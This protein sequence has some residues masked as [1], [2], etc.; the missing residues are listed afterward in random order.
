MTLVRIAFTFLATCSLLA[1]GATDGSG[2]NGASSGAGSGGSGANGAVSGTGESTGGNDDTGAASGSSG[3]SS[4]GGAAGTT[5]GVTGSVASAS[6]NAGAGGSSSGGA[7]NAGGTAGAMGD[8]PACPTEPPDDGFLCLQ[9]ALY[10]SHTC[11]YEDCAGSG[12][13]LA[14]C[15]TEILGPDNVQKRWSVQTA[16]CGETVQCSQ[17]NA[18]G[19][20][21]ALGDVCLVRAG[22]A[23]IVECVES[24]C[25]TGPIGCDCVSGCSGACSLSGTTEGATLSCNTCPSGLCP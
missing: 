3:S 25:G 15:G 6:G 13:T 14:R 19:T 12:R 20:T 21:C 10:D 5:S 7:G 24:S 18:N 16:P 11:I 1:C 9:G 2:Q 17:A 23:L 4:Q 22:G 8:T